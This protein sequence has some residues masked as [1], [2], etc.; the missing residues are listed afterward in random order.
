MQV[1]ISATNWYPIS[2]EYP[3]DTKLSLQPTLIQFK[4]GYKVFH[5]PI[6]EQTRNVSINKQTAFY[7]STAGSFFDFIKETTYDNIDLGSYITLQLNGSYVNNINNVMYLSGGLSD[8]SFFRLIPN[9]DDTYSLMNGNSKYVTVQK[10]MP[11]ALTLE[12]PVSFTDAST[13][14]FKIF[15]PD[16]THIYFTTITDNPNPGYGPSTIQRFWSFSSTTSAMRAIGIVSDDDY[17]LLNP[18]LFEVEGF[19]LLSNLDGLTR[20]QTWVQYY[21]QLNNIENNKNVELQDIKC[22]SGVDISR[23]IDL[24]FYSQI[25]IGNQTGNMKVNFA[26][27]KNIMTPEYEYHIR[28]EKP[29]GIN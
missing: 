8:N 29:L 26:N 27:M 15:S 24:P 7:L 14:K 4:D 25:D 28:S 19:S 9:Y 22:I 17:T 18:Y 5:H 12:D 20:D 16:S 21:N 6:F 2:A 3:Y 23:L 10:R 11:F 1:S 13:Q